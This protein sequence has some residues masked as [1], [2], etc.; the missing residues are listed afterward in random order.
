MGARYLFVLTV[1]LAAFTAGLAG[2]ALLWL[3]RAEDPVEL[4]LTL[5]VSTAIGVTLA[6]ILLPICYKLGPEKAR[7]FLYLLVFVPMIAIILLTRVN[8]NILELSI[9]FLDALPPSK[10]VGVVALLPL[11]SLAAMLVSYLISCRIAAGKE[12]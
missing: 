3:A 6:V 8:T 10:L 4:A 2:C 12:Y 7:T 1:F 5:L 11:G 9:A